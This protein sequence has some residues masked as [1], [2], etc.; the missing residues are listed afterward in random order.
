MKIVE[1]TAP[2]V[3][4]NLP[5]IIGTFYPRSKCTRVA[6]CDDARFLKKHSTCIENLYSQTI[7]VSKNY[8][9]KLNKKCSV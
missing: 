2:V 1:A 5:K 9:N 4:S 3:A 6:V 8:N 7:F